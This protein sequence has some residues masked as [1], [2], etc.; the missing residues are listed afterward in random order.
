MTLHCHR[1][2]CLAALLLGTA[3][4]ASAG[5]Y[6]DFFAAIAKDDAATVV[7][8]LRRGFDPNTRDPNGQHGLFLAIRAPSPR[9][10]QA[11]IDWPQTEVESLNK[12]DE[13]PLMAA[14]L[15]GQL[16]LARKLIARGAAVNKTGWTPLHYATTNG[17]VE[18][19]RLLLEEHAFIDPESPNKTTP[20]MMAA[21]YGSAD[22]VRLL[23]QE[24]AEPLLKNEQGMT[25]IDFANSVNRADVAKLIG[26]AVR[27][28]Q[29]RGK[30]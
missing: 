22:A 2:H 14:A 7:N 26:D 15:G 21:R 17:H 19:M 18:V 27:Q 9:V 11:L 3:G 25:A 10:A 24:G 1:R 6:E 23:L 8:L 28:R 29:P 30:W 13:S 12:A 16:E 4:W 5:S 20:L